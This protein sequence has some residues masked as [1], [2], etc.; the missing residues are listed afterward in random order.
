[1]FLTLSQIYRYLSSIFFLF[2]FYAFS[3][4]AN[5]Q[6]VRVAAL[7]YGTVSWELDVIKHHGLA[8]KQ[9]IE[10]EILTSH[11][12]ANVLNASKGVES[13]EQH[14][15]SKIGHHANKVGVIDLWQQHP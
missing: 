10:L 4:Q 13:G 3:I 2:F 7:K 1:M 15:N 6:V 11:S 14:A 12:V 9:G 8:E 5:A